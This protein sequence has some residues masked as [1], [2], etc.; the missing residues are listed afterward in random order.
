MSKK[1]NIVQKILGIL[2]VILGLWI[3]LCSCTANKAACPTYYSNVKAKQLMKKSAFNAWT[4]D[5]CHVKK[6]K[7]KKSN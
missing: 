3:M 6:K 5:F 4:S 7:Y 2:L 1:I